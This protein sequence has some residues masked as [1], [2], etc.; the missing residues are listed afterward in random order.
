M[1][2]RKIIAIIGAFVI[3]GMTLAISSTMQI[4]EAGTNLN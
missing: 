4:A 2:M 1:V 3:G